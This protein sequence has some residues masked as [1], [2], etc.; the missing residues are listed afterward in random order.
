[1]GKSEFVARIVMWLCFAT[2]ALSLAVHWRLNNSMK[3]DAHSQV[4]M[5]KKVQLSSSQAKPKQQFFLSHNSQATGKQN[6]SRNLQGA[7]P[8][9]VVDLSDRRVYVYRQSTVVASYPI[10]VGK[11]G[12]ETP[13]GAFQV[14]H[15]QHNPAWRHPITGQ[16][17]PAGPNSPLGL[18]WIGFWT[19]GHSH[20]GFHGTPNAD[21]VGNPVSHGCLRMRNS[22]VVSLY[23]HV[24]LGTKVE[25]KQ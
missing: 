11:K 13:T 15:M 1:M 5:S 6:S 20:I 9:L 8:N 23:N 24:A 21:V 7:K 3:A 4:P 19:D 14:M 10:G 12:W 18:R 2:S 17:F 16:V 22:D 25:V